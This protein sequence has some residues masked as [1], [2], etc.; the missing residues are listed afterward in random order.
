MLPLFT[1]ILIAISIGIAALQIFGRL[2][3]LAAIADVQ[4]P[5]VSPGRY[6]PMLRLLSDDDIAFVASNKALARKLRARRIQIFRDYLRC[7]TKDY[8]RL[9]AHL[10]LAM[11]RSG[12]DRPDLART[13][14]RNEFFFGL[15]ICRIEFRLTLY[16]AGLG[17]VDV[18][19]LVE[20]IDALR[21][22]VGAFGP[23]ALAA[24]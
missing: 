13:I 2:R 4:A 8:G 10:R 22:Q 12:V 11:V 21:T 18:S 20:A 5:L 1:T 23:S 24:H 3:H 16:W 17:K 19:G 15:A 9:L 6:R 7:L 14:A